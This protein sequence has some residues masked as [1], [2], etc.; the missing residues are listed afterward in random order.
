MYACIHSTKPKFSRAS[1]RLSNAFDA[2]LLFTHPVSLCHDLTRLGRPGLPPKD[3]ASLGPNARDSEA[4]VMIGRRLDFL[5]TW[6][7][8]CVSAF[9][10]Y[11]N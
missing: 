11:G 7:E 4:A 2:S 1:L 9:G 5:S 8:A 3:V 6:W 10:T